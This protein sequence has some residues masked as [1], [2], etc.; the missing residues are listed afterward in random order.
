MVLSFADEVSSSALVDVLLS[1]PSAEG[2]R[3]S[4]AADSEAETSSAGDEIA[5]TRVN[6][7]T[8]TFNAPPGQLLPGARLLNSLRVRKLQTSDRGDMGARIL[9]LN[10]PKMGDF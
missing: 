8:Y 6:A 7:L 5:A 4:V 9:P 1:T 10:S 2:R 3:L